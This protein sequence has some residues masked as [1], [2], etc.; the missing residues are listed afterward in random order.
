M[1]DAPWTLV[2][3]TEDALTSADVEHITS[4]HP[5]DDVTYWVL[6]PS[7]SGHNVVTSVLDHLGMLELR[8]AWDEIVGKEPSPEEADATAAE[9]VVESVAL[10]RAAGATAEG[11]ITQDDPMAALQAAVAGGA[12]EVVVVTYPRAVEDTF[13]LDWASKAREV[14]QVPVLHLYTGT[15]EIG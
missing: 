2:V 15:S 9:Q 5:D 11:E 4:L 14:L 1:S 12:Q 10:L 6:V 8:A 3:L 7:E 13:H